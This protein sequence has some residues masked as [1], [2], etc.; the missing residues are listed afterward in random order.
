MKESIVNQLRQIA[1]D[2]DFEFSESFLTLGTIEEL[3]RVLGN[4]SNTLNQT[5]TTEEVR[6]LNYPDYDDFDYKDYQIWVNKQVMT[7][8]VFYYSQSREDFSQWIGIKTAAKYGKKFV[9][10][11]DLS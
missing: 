10:L 3:N 9:I 1:K 8:N 5:V 6:I 4:F 11:E 7:G 2:N